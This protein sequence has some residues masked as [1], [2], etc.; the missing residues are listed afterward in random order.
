MHMLCKVFHRDMCISLYTIH[1]NM[2]KMIEN[3][4]NTLINLLKK[5]RSKPAASLHN[6]T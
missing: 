2:W 1:E 4:K 3:L 6:M 5:I